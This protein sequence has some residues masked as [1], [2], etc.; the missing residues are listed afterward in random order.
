MMV[1]QKT[2][3]NTEFTENEVQLN[4]SFI[5]KPHCMLLLSLTPFYF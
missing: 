1:Y 2:L 4:N 5:E 3:E